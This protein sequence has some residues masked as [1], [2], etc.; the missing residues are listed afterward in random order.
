MALKRKGETAQE[1]L[2]RCRLLAKRTVPCSTNSVLQQTY[3]EQAEQMLLSA[4]SK[5]LVG[6]P[7]RQVRYASPATAEE[8]LH[9]AV[10]V[11]GRNARS[12]R[13]CVLSRHR[14]HRHYA[15]WA[16]RDY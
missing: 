5:G 3:N 12:A 15:S 10:T 13:Q 1:F 4:F 14:G 16:A 6:T 8:A 7:G 9:I 11:S 2:D